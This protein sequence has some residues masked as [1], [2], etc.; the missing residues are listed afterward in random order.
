M[1]FCLDCVEAFRAWRCL[2]QRLRF[3]EWRRIV[4]GRIQENDWYLVELF[5]ILMSVKHLFM[6]R[7]VRDVTK[8]ISG[9]PR[10]LAVHRKT[11]RNDP[12][13]RIS[14]LRLRCDEHAVACAE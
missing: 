10:Q 13:D 3:A 8:R 2:V 4:A 11:Y 1:T 14:E 6:R 5:E 9:F 12:L 7:F